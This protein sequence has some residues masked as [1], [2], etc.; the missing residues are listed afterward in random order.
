MTVCHP[1]LT[2]GRKTVGR[3][4]FA[5]TQCSLGTWETFSKSQ[6]GTCFHFADISTKGGGD[7]WENV[8]GN[9]SKAL[10]SGMEKVLTPWHNYEKYIVV[11]AKLKELLVI[12]G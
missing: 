3:V 2:K 8:R 11:I 6:Y 9:Y 1:K 5:R 10:S 4:L 12:H 7:F